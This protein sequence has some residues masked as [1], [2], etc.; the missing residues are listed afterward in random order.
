[1][2]VRNESLIRVTGPRFFLIMAPLNRIF[3]HPQLPNLQPVLPSPICR[4]LLHHF[5]P[6]VDLWLFKLAFPSPKRDLRN[7]QRDL[8]P[9]LL[10]MGTPNLPRITRRKNLRKKLRDT[11]KNPPRS[12]PRR[13]ESTPPAL[14]LYLHALNQ[15]LPPLNR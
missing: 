2:R 3:I 1:M 6:R 7:T 8:H 11:T 15:N 10:M 5:S 14:C 4:L 9:L 12:C 13:Q